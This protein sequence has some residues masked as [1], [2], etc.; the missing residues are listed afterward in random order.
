MTHMNCATVIS[1]GTR[2]LCL[3]RSLICEFGCRSTITYSTAV[4]NFMKLNV[5]SNIN[6]FVKTCK[7]TKIIRGQLITKL[8]ITARM[9]IWFMPSV[10]YRNTIWMLLLDF[11][12]ITKTLICKKMLEKFE[13]HQ[14]KERDSLKLY[15]ITSTD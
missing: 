8:H 7:L 3:S 15:F 14:P 11:S 4:N 10:S 5:K 12:C 9:D 1:T 6:L 13:F 2:N